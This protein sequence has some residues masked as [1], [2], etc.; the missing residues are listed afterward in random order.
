MSSE[1]LSSAVI[2]LVVLAACGDTTAPSSTATAEAMKAS[3]LLLKPGVTVLP[4]ATAVAVS[5]QR[6]VV[7]VRRSAL[8]L[9]PGQVF[10]AGSHAYRATSL[11]DLADGVEVATEEPSFSDVFD[12]IS[13]RG[14][15][16]I[17]ASDVRTEGAATLT[18]PSATPATVLPAGNALVTVSSTSS[19]LVFTLKDVVV[20]DLSASNASVRIIANGT[21]T[22]DTPT[23]TFDVTSNP[24]AAPT[25]K[26]GFHAGEASD[27]TL[28][29]P[30]AHVDASYVVPLA[31][32]QVSIPYTFNMVA[33][34]GRIDL[35]ITASGEAHAVVTFTE[36][37]SLDAGLVA[38]GSTVTPASTVTS[39]FSAAVPTVTGAVTLGASLRPR[40]SLLV[41]QYDIAGMY[42]RVGVEVS[43]LGSVTAAQQCVDVGI[44]AAVGI[45]G[46]VSLPFYG[47]DAPLYAN[48]WPLYSSHTCNP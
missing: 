45:N 37:V 23:I 33:I 25:A 40:L 19:A 21:V 10:I 43:A 14:E 7:P 44:S 31:T 22:L 32:F 39:H 29:L 1:R 11:T 20:A 35:V 28:D 38:Q 5:G 42:A 9:A 4:E 27:L 17:G 47:I 24:N 34:G 12:A 2:I 16:T 26:L 3:G 18:V 36:S 46:Y 6:L 15:A 8:D 41:L 30:A 48:Q 13:L